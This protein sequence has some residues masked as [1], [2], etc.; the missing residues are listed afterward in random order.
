MS[1]LSPLQPAAASTNEAALQEVIRSGEAQQ[2]KLEQLL[3]ASTA[4]HNEEL[5]D[6][7]AQMGELKALLQQLVP[8]APAPAPEPEPS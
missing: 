1:T 8:A 6:L 5:R 2:A 4:A 3:E 7:K